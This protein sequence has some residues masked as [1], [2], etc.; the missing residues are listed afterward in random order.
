MRRLERVGMAVAAAATTAGVLVIGACAQQVPGTALADRTELSAYAS[1]VT[2]SAAAGRATDSACDAF[3]TANGS[4]VR[5]FHVYIDASN[6]KGVDDP[7]TKRKAD[8]AVT[9]LRDNAHSVDQSVTGSVPSAIAYPLGAYRDD[10][11]ALADTLARE[12]DTDTL[13]AVIAEFNAAKDDALT[14]C[15]T[16]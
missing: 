8:S 3:R 16:H 2:S 5:A 10:T 15:S 1:A 6:S 13:N 14:A 4:S 9:T 12:P 11:N 7:E